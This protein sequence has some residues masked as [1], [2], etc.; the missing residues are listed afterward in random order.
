MKRMICVVKP[1]KS[2][3]VLYLEVQLF[4]DILLH[5]ES[6]A[7]FFLSFICGSDRRNMFTALL[8]RIEDCGL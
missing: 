7:E 6:K 4:C 8:H 2:A 3:G 5:A 1:E